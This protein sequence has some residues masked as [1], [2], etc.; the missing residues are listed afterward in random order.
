MKS[1]VIALVLAGSLAAAG[2][3][4][5]TH[6]H[7]APAAE[8]T[9]FSGAKVV[10]LV[11]ADDQSLRM[12]AE[13]ALVRAL[14]ARGIKAVAA[15]R[16]I[17]REELKTKDQARRWFEQ[18]G[19]EGVVALRPIELK[20][21]VTEYAPQW[22]TSYYQSFYGYYGYGWS[23]A[24]IPGGRSSQTSVVVEATVFSIP[25]DLLLWGAVSQTTNPKNMDAYM[26]DL[27]G[28]AVKEIEKAGLIR[29]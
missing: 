8:A 21:T 22:A 28:N 12:S 11:I 1:A 19:A 14:T 17:P 20:T 16:T 2:D 27:V 7:R 13:E 15:W 10:A 29:R 26:K 5:F 18:A 23:A 25:K 6:V 24:Y 3:I 4:R 9:S